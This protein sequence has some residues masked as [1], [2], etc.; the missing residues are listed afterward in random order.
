MN[1]YFI[2]ASSQYLLQIKYFGL[3][4]PNVIQATSLKDVLSLMKPD[5]II[6]MGYRDALCQKNCV[7]LET[8]YELF[9]DKLIGQSVFFPEKTKKY[10]Y[11]TGFY[12]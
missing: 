4:D 7:F 3:L 9:V 12:S 6:F 11:G 8:G 10:N 5:E 1:S 2:P